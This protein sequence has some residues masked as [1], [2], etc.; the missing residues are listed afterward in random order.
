[1]SRR[2]LLV[3]PFCKAHL[4]SHMFQGPLVRPQ[5]H[6]P[7][8]VKQTHQA[9]G[10]STTPTHNSR[11]QAF[12]PRLPRRVRRP[13]EPHQLLKILG[14]R[15]DGVHPLLGRARLLPRLADPF[16]RQQPQHGAD[17]V[18]GDAVQGG[19]D[20][21]DVPPLHQGDDRDGAVL[22]TCQ[23]EKMYRCQVLVGLLD[24]RMPYERMILQGGPD[25]VNL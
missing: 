15:Q 12:P 23:Q 24:L 1:V 21:V 16:P 18:R 8:H 7:M 6:I 14:L 9:R 19:A 13:H 22:D 5:K 25:I 3:S 17:A 2:F 10:R 4:T 20:V 11:E